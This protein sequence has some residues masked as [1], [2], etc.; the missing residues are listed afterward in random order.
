MMSKPAPSRCW[1]NKESLDYNVQEDKNTHAEYS[2][3]LMLLVFIDS[4]ETLKT[5]E[6]SSDARRL[7]W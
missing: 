2:W 6:V 1:L 7:G 5:A 4:E 3:G